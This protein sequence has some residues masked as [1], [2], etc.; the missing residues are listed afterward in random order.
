MKLFWKRPKPP[1]SEQLLPYEKKPGGSEQDALLAFFDRRDRQ[2][3]ALIKIID[4]QNGSTLEGLSLKM[5]S[6]PLS[7]DVDLWALANDSKVQQDLVDAFGNYV[8]YALKGAAERSCKERRFTE[9]PSSINRAIE[10]KLA[11][12]PSRP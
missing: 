5:D 6:L 9:I 1:P 10:N 3:E 4:S 11:T 7:I 2:Q 8:E 12:W